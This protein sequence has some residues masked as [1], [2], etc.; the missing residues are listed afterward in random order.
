MQAAAT[1]EERNNTDGQA[2]VSC[3]AFEVLY[4]VQVESKTNKDR[5]IIE[6]CPCTAPGTPQARLTDDKCAHKSIWREDGGSLERNSTCR[7]RLG[8]S[9]NE[10]RLSYSGAKRRQPPQR[11]HSRAGP[12][13]DD[14]TS[15][16]AQ[17]APPAYH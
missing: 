4:F 12:R 14:Q 11:R 8:R 3:I 16:S 6:A 13:P 10:W 1:S 7:P 9:G 17:P 15:Q 5:K 2:S